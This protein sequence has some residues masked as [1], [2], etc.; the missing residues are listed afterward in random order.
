MA[1]A[2]SDVA[3]FMSDFRKFCDKW[4]LMRMATW[5]LPHPQGPMLPNLLPVGAPA[6]P[7]HG[8]HVIVPVHYPLHGDDALQQM[9]LTEQRQK[10]AEIGIDATVAGLPH[11]KLYGQFLPIIHVERTLE[12]RLGPGARPKGFISRLENA[13]ADVLGCSVDH[14]KTLRKAVSSCRRG[15]RSSLKLLQPPVH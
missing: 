8:V 3:A 14:V 9:I 1:P 5:D 11:H 7:M 13:L 15:K 6:V 10:A 2:D 4:G 12:S